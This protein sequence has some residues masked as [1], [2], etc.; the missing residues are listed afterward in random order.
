MKKKNYPRRMGNRDSAVVR[1]LASHQYGQ[2]SVWVEFVVGSRPCSDGF[3]SGS[4]VFAP[5]QKQTLSTNS[6][7]SPRA[8]GLSVCYVQPSLNKF[9]LLSYF[10]YYL[11]FIVLKYFLSL[12][13]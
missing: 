13:V 5:P 8:I 9:D 3:S 1:V 10:L 7:R 4:P 2:G 12:K 6:I 11:L